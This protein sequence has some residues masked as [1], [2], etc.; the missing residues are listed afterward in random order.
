MFM[1][2]HRET[3]HGFLTHAREFLIAAEVVV[4]RAE[5]IS[6]LPAYFLYGRS[7]ELSLKSFLLGCGLTAKALA[8][9][10]FG[11]N[12]VALLEEA[13][14]QGLREHVALEAVESG[15]IRLLSYD[16]MEKRLEYRVTGGLYHLP[17]IDVTER[18][19]RRLVVEL[20]HAQGSS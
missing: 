15:V 17:L 9:R 4:N 2:D 11:H 7:V 13:E 18:V 1:S 20:A 16:Y 3:S 12:L 6:A 8:A 10:A 5:G 19:A 14:V